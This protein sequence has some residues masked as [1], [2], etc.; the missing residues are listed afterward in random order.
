MGIQRSG[1]NRSHGWRTEWMRLAV[2]PRLSVKTPNGC[3]VKR[4]FLVACE[5]TVRRAVVFGKTPTIHTRQV[6]R[7]LRLCDIKPLSV[8]HSRVW[9]HPMLLKIIRYSESLTRDGTE[10]TLKL[11]HQISFTHSLA[12]SLARSPA[13]PT[14]HPFTQSTTHCPIT[15]RSLE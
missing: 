14:T 10:T 7:L 2:D 13:H 12:R 3:P 15:R 1:Q 9:I 4:R 11:P 8:A 5:R 6:L